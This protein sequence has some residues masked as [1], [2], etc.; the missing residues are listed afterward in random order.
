MFAG[1]IFIL[2]FY[3]LSWLCLSGRA[4]VSHD[5]GLISGTAVLLFSLFL[6][7]HWMR[8]LQDARNREHE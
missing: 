2:T 7:Y 6:S 1:A 8:E 3:Y 5:F 4:D